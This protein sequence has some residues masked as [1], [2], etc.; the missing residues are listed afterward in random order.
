MKSE[1]YTPDIKQRLDNS[2]KELLEL[3]RMS[4]EMVERGFRLMFE[5]GSMVEREKEEWKSLFNNEKMEE[6]DRILMRKIEIRLA[7]K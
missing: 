2:E 6:Y 5:L 3:K 7:A 4:A 1:D